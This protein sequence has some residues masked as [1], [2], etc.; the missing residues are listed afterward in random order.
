MLHFQRA[1]GRANLSPG[2]VVQLDP[3]RVTF[4]LPT[5]HARRLRVGDRATILLVDDNTPV[6]AEIEMISPVTEAESGTVRVKM[7]LANPDGKLRAGVR[8][9]LSLATP[10]SAPVNQRPNP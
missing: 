7:R 4:G 2:Y 6:A 5:G 3:L 8:C 9:A 1:G 10:V